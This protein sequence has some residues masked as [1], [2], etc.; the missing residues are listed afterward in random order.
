MVLGAV[1][2]IST[3][4][5]VSNADLQSALQGSEQ[6]PKLRNKIPRWLIVALEVEKYCSEEKEQHLKNHKNQVFMGHR[7]KEVV[8]MVDRW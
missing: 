7:E 5:P 1:A 3:W 2:S 4:E 8:V 6:E